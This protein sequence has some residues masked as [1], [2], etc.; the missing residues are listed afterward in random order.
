MAQA[1][2]SIL[3][4]QLKESW[5]R[6]CKAVK[7][8]QPKM[9]E[10]SVHDLRVALR[11]LDSVL[12]LIGLFAPESYTE[13]TRD[14]LKQLRK[15][16]NPLRDVQVQLLL[17]TDLLNTYPD[18]QKFQKKLLKREQSLRRDLE[19]EVEAGHAKLEKA[20]NKTIVRSRNLLRAFDAPQTK[21]VLE[22]GAH[23]GYSALVD[24][25]RAIDPNDISSIHKMRIAF[26]RFRYT[27]QAAQ[28]ILRD[29][30][31]TMFERMHEFQD[32]LGGVQ[33][34]DVLFESL[35]QWGGK[36]KDNT[37]RSL[38]PVYQTVAQRRRD[39]VQKLLADMGDMQTFW[40]QR[41]NDSKPATIR[42]IG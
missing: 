22:A 19:E 14:R 31:A 38:A 33:D 28:P 23:T 7:R 24:S 5:G 30:P 27:T 32:L 25:M 15:R 16:L 3:A 18:L 13:K 9:T 20:F 2:A 40:Q 4:T 17:L 41:G 21:E 39:A 35:T 36:Q 8:T 37:Q 1:R 11:R 34:A 42:A 10:K 6:Y 29:T 26:K 12:G